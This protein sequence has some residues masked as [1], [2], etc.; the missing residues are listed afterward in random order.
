MPVSTAMA[1]S[2]CGAL[3]LHQVE[4]RLGRIEQGLLLRQVESRGDAARVAGLHQLQSLLLN[5][6]RLLHDLGF[7]V[8]LAQAEVVGGE[9]GR[10]HQV[11]VVQV[12]CGGLQRCVGGLQAALDLAEQVGLVVQQKRNLEG[13]L[14]ERSAQRNNFRAI[15]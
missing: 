15:S 1:C 8:E 12:G 5:G 14:R 11:H 3:L 6:D 4:L 7:G 10:E 13:V 2:N 9:F